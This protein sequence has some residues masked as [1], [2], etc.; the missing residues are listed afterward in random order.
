VEMLG[1]GL[2]LCGGFFGRGVHL[3]NA[4]Y[5][6][7]GSVKPQPCSQTSC[8]LSRPLRLSAPLSAALSSRAMGIAV[9]FLVIER[10]AEGFGYR[11]IS[12]AQGAQS[13]KPRA[14]AGQ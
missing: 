6:N 5:E 14:V 8:T 10:A 4:A 13:L 1:V 11:R 3:A 9:V 7:R 2:L 12:G